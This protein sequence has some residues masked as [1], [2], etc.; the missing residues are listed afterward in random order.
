MEI[1]ENK[2]GLYSCKFG[3]IFIIIC[4][5][6]LSHKLAAVCRPLSGN[7]AVEQQLATKAFAALT[8]SFK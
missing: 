4:S 2:C 3:T 6:T 7:V 8:F 5:L 1:W